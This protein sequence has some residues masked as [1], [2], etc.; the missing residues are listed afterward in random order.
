[1]SKKKKNQRSRP[2][3]VF[4][5]FVSVIIPVH[6]RIDLLTEC[7]NALPAAF[8]DILYEVIIIDN[9]TPK[10]ETKIYTEWKNS[11]NIRIYPQ[12]SN[13]G[14]P[15]AC[16]LGMVKSYAPLIFFLNSDVIMDKGS[17][18]VLVG[19]L[20]DPNVG[21]VGMK[22]LFPQT[23]DL[24][25]NTYMRPAGKV[26]HVGLATNA[27]AEFYHVFLGWDANHP[28][29]NAI[30]KIYAATGAA[31]MTR[32]RLFRDAGG[33]LEQYGRGTY[34]DVD[35]CLTVQEMGYNVIVDINAVGIHHTGATTEKYNLPYSLNQNRMIFMQRWV[36]KLQYT[37]WWH[38]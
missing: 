38:L 18:E 19:S 35:Y 26:Q 34:E 10:E 2:N 33:F 12:I 21:V 16:N 1:M 3:S 31:L 17:G 27:R 28:K 20:D 6:R 5:P 4:T 32:K 25:Q 24:P 22:L 37:E 36:N 14:Y 29:V 23:T 7:V 11:P 30:R 8:G 15:K 13:L 9:N